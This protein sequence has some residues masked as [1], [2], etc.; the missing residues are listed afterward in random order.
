[1]GLGITEYKLPLSTYHE[2]GQAI[3]CGLKI[4]TEYN[5][6]G[7]ILLCPF[8]GLKANINS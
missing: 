5:C 3:K 1:M 4:R 8:L 2:T 7:F 6:S